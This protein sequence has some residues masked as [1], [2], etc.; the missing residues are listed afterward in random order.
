MKRRP[1]LFLCLALASGLVA[2]GSDEPQRQPAV[3]ASDVAQETDIASDPDL[4]DDP[5]SDTL[6]DIDPDR[7]EESTANDIATDLDENGETSD[8]GEGADE[9]DAGPFE[10]PEALPFE[11]TRPVAG[12]APTSEEIAEFT[13]RMTGLWKEIDY[14]RWVRMTS[15]GIDPSNE[16]GWFDYALWWQDTQAIR[17]GDAV[18]FRHYGRADNLTM[19]TSR[20]LTVAIA[21]YL[22][23]GDE[24]MRWIIEQYSRGL[25][26]LSMAMEFIPDDPYRYLQARAL[27]TR[28]H[29]YQTVD[30]REVIIDYDPVRRDEVSWNA[31]I[32]HNPDNPYWGD[33]WFVNQ[34]SK[35]DVPHMFRAVPMLLRAVQDAPDESVRQAAELALEYLGG[36]ARD[37]VDSGYQI[38]T[39]F[40]DGEPVVPMNES[41]LV[42][43]L[44]SLVLYERSVPNAECNGKLSSALV[45]YVEPLENDCEAGSGGLYETIATMGHYFNYAIIRYFHIAAVHNALMLR[46]NDVALELLQGLAARADAMVYDLTMPNRDEPTWMADV[47]AFLLAAAAAGLPLTGDEARIVQEQYLLSVDHYLAFDAWDPWDPDFPQGAFNYMPDRG[48]AVRPTEI[49]FL[50]EYCYSPFRNPAG[51]PVADCEVVADPARWGEPEVEK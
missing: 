16:E 49:G 23:T 3:D 19:R 12:T 21:G 47:A 43:D 10:W 33:I 29:S 44:A 38:R 40:D 25:A 51:V 20:I 14:F 28:N 1:L 50:L 13:R 22:L 30:G 9:E 42:K 5:A 26:A 7:D 8:T 36:F 24:Q 4:P 18:I 41:G 32:I 17:E 45:G 35:D 39:R 2:C 37:I 11:F 34:R 6:A 46:H 27:F 15:H 48:V 31:A